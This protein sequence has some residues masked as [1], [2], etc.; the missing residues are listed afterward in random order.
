MNCNN[1]SVLLK[2]STI[3]EN[4]VFICSHNCGSFPQ[5]ECFVIQSIKKVTPFLPCVGKV[6]SLISLP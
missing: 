4:F 3:G 2:H 5:N 6:L 1:W